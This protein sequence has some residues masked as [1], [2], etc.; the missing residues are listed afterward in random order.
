MRSGM[1]S[2]D[3]R[4]VAVMLYPGL[5]WGDDPMFPARSFKL[6][7]MPGPGTV[8]QSITVP[9]ASAITKPSYLSWREAA[10]IPLAALTAWR[11]L[12]TKARLQSGEKIL[13]TGAGG[14][15]ALF[16]VQIAVAMG[17]QVHVTSSSEATLGEAEALGAVAGY[18]YTRE[19]WKS[20]LPRSSQGFHVVFDSAPA[21]GYSSYSRST[22]TGA[23]IVLYGSTGGGTIP[24]S[25]PE[26]FL[27]NLQLLGT[28]AGTLQEFREML[29]FMETHRIKPVIDRCFPLEEAMDALHFLQ[30]GHAFG[31]VVIDVGTSC[32]SNSGRT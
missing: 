9:L 1:E 32:P 30:N 22:V 8:A 17:A 24:V 21:S 27:K 10:A 25:A 19:G 3:P 31:K 15:V 16:A 20:G 13:I 29:A 26:L 18:N 5:E 12:R 7:G 28:N 14:G 11:G 6:L 23:R 2:I 4:S